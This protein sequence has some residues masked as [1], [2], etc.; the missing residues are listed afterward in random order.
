[1]IRCVRYGLL[2]LCALPAHAQGGR[3][4]G[5]GAPLVLFVRSERTAESKEIYDAAWKALE[6]H[7]GVLARER[8]YAFDGER[9]RAELFF[10]KH[11]AYR[12]VV[13][14]DEQARD[15]VPKRD[16]AVLVDPRADR[17]EIAR[18]IRLL[19]PLA[20]RVFVLGKPDEKL[21]GF[22]IV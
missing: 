11:A 16:R 1:M 7:F 12:T 22:K 4:T 20:R 19:R 10:A 9:R 3:D 21:A 15:W 5:R 2:L 6:P 17:R 14:F 8:L 18:V 13:C